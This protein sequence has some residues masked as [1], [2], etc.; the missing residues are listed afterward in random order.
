VTPHPGELQAYKERAEWAEQELRKVRRELAEA[1]IERRAE[2]QRQAEAKAAAEAAAAEEKRLE[3]YR[4]RAWVNY[5]V[6]K[7]LGP[8]TKTA[9]GLSSWVGAVFRSNC[10]RDMLGVSISVDV[11][12]LKLVA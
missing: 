1:A 5:R 11:A 8:S 7:A 12:G 9:Q 6:D 10:R 3:E 4:R 2:L